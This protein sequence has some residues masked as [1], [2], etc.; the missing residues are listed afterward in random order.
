MYLLFNRFCYETRQLLN[1]QE[2][3][4]QDHISSQIS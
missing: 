1:K 3:F 4:L 2:L